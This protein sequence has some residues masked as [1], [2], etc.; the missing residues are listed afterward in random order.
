MINSNEILKKCCRYEIIQVIEN[1]SE[2]RK[3]KDGLYPLC[4]YC[5]K[6]CYLKNLD[7]NKIYNEQNKKRRN[8][9]PKNKRETI[10]N[11]RLIGN[12]R[13]RIYKSLKGMTK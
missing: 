2:D 5:R 7:K 3:S 12:T 6:D 13:S 9:Y 10:I 11:F 1:F 8:R 4:K